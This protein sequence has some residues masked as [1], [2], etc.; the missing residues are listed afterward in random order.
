AW[1]ASLAANGLAAVL[2]Q[3]RGIVTAPPATAA[4]IITGALQ[5]VKFE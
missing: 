3:G 1:R 4:R 5:C 2:G